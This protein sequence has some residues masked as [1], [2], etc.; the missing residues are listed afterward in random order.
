MSCPKCGSTDIVIVSAEVL[1]F[2]CRKC[3]HTWSYDIRPGLVNTPS[4][5]VHWTDY[6][7]YKEQALEDAKDLIKRGEQLDKILQELKQKYGNY[8]TEEEIQ[9]I[10][11]KAQILLKYM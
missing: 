10:I 3:G 8:L 4:G 6:M 1:T 5:P 7:Y 11:K 9:R 2:K